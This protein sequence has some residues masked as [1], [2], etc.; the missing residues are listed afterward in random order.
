MNIKQAIEQ[1]KE[2]LSKYILENQRV[3]EISNLSFN[4]IL[5][6]D[7]MKNSTVKLVIERPEKS[8]MMNK[9]SIT[10][11]VDLVANELA[12]KPGAV[13]HLERKVDNEVAYS[14]MVKNKDMFSILLRMESTLKLLDK[15][16]YNNFKFDWNSVSDILASKG[17][18]REVSHKLKPE[19]SK[20]TNEL[21]ITHT[22]ID[23]VCQIDSSKS[24]VESMLKRSVQADMIRKNQLMKS[25]IMILNKEI[26][27]KEVD[28]ELII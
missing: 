9:I 5:G 8:F 2:S 4:L 23:G 19:I 3:L 28:R 6:R 10:R 25:P 15:G 22:D 18:N 26:S 24:L 21:L 1:D 11:I 17:I 12:I 20:I 16:L 27:N 13:E 14:S 7:L